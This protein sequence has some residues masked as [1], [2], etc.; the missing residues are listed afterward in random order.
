MHILRSHLLA[1]WDNGV[2]C[3]FLGCKVQNFWAMA[4]ILCLD[5]NQAH[6][7][8]NVFYHT[9]HTGRLA[10]SKMATDTELVFVFL[11]FRWMSDH[12]ELVTIEWASS[13]LV[14]DQLE[15]VTIGQTQ[16]EV[17]F[18][19]VWVTISSWQGTLS[20]WCI[21]GSEAIMPIQACQSVE[22]KIFNLIH[23]QIVTNPMLL[24]AICALRRHMRRCCLVVSCSGAMLLS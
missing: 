18:N 2:Q 19:S 6:V 9:T 5:S 21:R 23:Y 8:R 14:V 20:E 16:E 10:S 13:N 17:N 12:F 24:V 7:P 15:M 3:A 1:N 4:T 11:I 22:R